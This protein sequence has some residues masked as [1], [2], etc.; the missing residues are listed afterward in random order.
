MKRYEEEAKALR[1]GPFT[2][3]LKVTLK[4][5]SIRNPVGTNGYMVQWV[6][7]VDG[8]WE[9]GDV[10]INE[11]LL[12]IHRAMELPNVNME[13]LHQYTGWIKSS[14]PIGSSRNCASSMP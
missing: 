4:V 6:N 7:K 8:D 14:P 1:E 2:Y 12:V 13:S 3:T 10:D 9:I 11:I 5:P